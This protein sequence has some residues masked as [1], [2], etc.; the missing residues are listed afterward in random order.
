[1]VNDAKFAA[2]IFAFERGDSPGC[3]SIGKT[4]WALTSLRNPRRLEKLLPPFGPIKRNLTAI[5]DS[6]N[7]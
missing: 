5:K 3:R 1:M 4:G 2:I 6:A 7:I